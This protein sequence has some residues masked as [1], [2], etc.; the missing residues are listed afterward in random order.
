MKNLFKII[1]NYITFKLGERKFGNPKYK[2]TVFIK[3]EIRKWVCMQP[4]I[5]NTAFM[6]CIYITA[7]NVK[8]K[9]KS[10]QIVIT[11]DKPGLLL[12]GPNGNTIE[13]LEKYLT[14][15]LFDFYI[16]QRK[17]NILKSRSLS[18]ERKLKTIKVKQSKLW[19]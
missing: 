2:L 17:M 10:I 1:K 13:S 6:Q 3:R 15:R 14:K 9:R 18:R 11:L 16:A 12:M 4:E 8:I 5:L 7:L 19:S